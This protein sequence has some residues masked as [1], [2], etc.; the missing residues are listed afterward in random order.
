MKFDRKILK[1]A[2]KHHLLESLYGTEAYASTKSYILNEATYEQL[3]N[4]AL[5]EKR[6]VKYLESTVLEAKIATQISAL[7]NSNV[8]PSTSVGKYNLVESA[9]TGKL[10]KRSVVSEATIKTAGWGLFFTKKN[11][12]STVQESSRAVALSFKRL[13]DKE[14]NATIKKSLIAEGKA[15][16]LRSKKKA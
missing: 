11:D 10:A 7:K 16:Y 8:K 6:D 9:V 15:W 3:L 14:T 5:N 13:A 2:L 12:G 4:L 1:A